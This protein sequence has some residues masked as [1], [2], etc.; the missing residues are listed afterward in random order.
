MVTSPAATVQ[1]KDAIE[2]NWFAVPSMLTDA[3]TATASGRSLD[4]ERPAVRGPAQLFMSGLVAETIADVV[5]AVELFRWHPSA[6]GYRFR[7]FVW[8]L[9]CDLADVP[10]Y[11]TALAGRLSSAAARRVLK[12]EVA[13]P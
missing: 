4:P 10:V 12:T 5:R 1:I 3:C 13:G 11:G 8:R 2:R 9:A 7:H 6:D